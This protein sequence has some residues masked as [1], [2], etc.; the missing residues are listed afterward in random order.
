MKYENTEKLLTNKL[1]QSVPNE[2][3]RELRQI[4]SALEINL[5]DI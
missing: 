5:A 3:Q 2:I 1:R 4:E